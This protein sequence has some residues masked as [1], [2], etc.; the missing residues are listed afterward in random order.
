MRA[1]EQVWRKRWRAPEGAGTAQ[2]SAE[3]RRAQCD[4]RF[5]VVAVFASMRDELVQPFVEAAAA[6]G[7]DVCFLHGARE[8]A[9]AGGS[10]TA[11]RAGAPV[12]WSGG[13]GIRRKPAG[14]DDAA[15][16]SESQDSGAQAGGTSR[17]PLMRFYRA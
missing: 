17:S 2:V 9:A 8:P 6:A 3:G 7:W 1:V 4:G 13:A 12:G 5:P 14:R 11:G 15:N 16:A 10:R